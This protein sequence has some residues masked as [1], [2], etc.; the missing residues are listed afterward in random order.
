MIPHYEIFPNKKGKWPWR[1]VAGNGEIIAE[2]GQGYFS[3]SNTRRAIR[4]LWELHGAT[5][6]PLMFVT[7]A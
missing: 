4:R 6:R 2:G 1:F 5:R 7:D 3:V